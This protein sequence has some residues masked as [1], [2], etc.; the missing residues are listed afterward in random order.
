ME[1]G[2]KIFCIVLLVF[3]CCCLGSCVSSFFGYSSGSYSGSGT[4]KITDKN[5]S[6]EVFENVE[7][8]PDKD[9]IFIATKGDDAAY[10]S[11]LRTAFNDLGFKV[12]T[13][14]DYDAIAD[15]TVSGSG[16]FIGPNTILTC[17]HVI[18]DENNVNVVFNNN[19]VKAKVVLNDSEADLAVLSVDV[20][21]DYYFRIL[22]DNSSKIA[23]SVYVLGYPLTNSLGT[24][25]RV[26]SGIIS[27]LTGI[28]GNTN[29]IQISASVQPGNSGGPVVN[30]D[31]A[32][33]GVVSSKL[34]DLY[35]L[36]T[37][38]QVSQNVN[39]AVKS[40]VIN[41]IAKK[42]KAE[43]SKRFV[44]NMDQ[45][46]GCTVI[47]TSGSE[48]SITEGNRYVCQFSYSLNSGDGF[49]SKFTMMLLDIKTSKVIASLTA[50]PKTKIKYDLK[51][52]KNIVGFFFDKVSYNVDKEN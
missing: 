36:Q 12:E 19:V 38:N 41:L 35:S 7:F 4:S 37:T 8:N 3:A 23:D 52:A 42:Y 24:D 10:A 34:S 30:T 40:D 14:Y 2:K 29:Y 39:F 1:I 47:V 13:I 18:T 25:I 21:S 48:N 49:F 15:K 43:D 26:T 6:S 22:S 9:V 33:L 32:V 20:K 46:S 28:N 11:K 51:T 27:A 5:M 16:F 50:Y 45:A 31:F 17:S 44:S